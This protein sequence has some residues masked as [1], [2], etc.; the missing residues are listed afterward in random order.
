MLRLDE[1]AF[2]SIFPAEKANQ[3]DAPSEEGLE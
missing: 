1:E 2:E 3:K